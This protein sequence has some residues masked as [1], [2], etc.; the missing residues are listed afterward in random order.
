MQ[1]FYI[2]FMKNDRL[3]GMHHWGISPNNMRYVRFYLQNL[4]D[5]FND[6]IHGI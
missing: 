1:E 6:S 2:F 3:Y 4:F 5:F